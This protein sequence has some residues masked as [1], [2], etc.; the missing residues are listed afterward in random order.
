MTDGSGARNGAP[1]GP[2]GYETYSTP[3]M[4]PFV[5]E[6]LDAVDLCPGDTVL[7]LACGTGFAA[8]A[9]AALVGPTGRVRGADHDAEMIRVARERHPRLYPDIEFTVAPAD[10]L[11]YDTAAF[12]VVV[13]QQG[14]QFFPDLDAVLAEVAR[15]T[16]PEGRF[17]ATVW[18]PVDRQPYFLAQQ[19]AVHEY[20]GPDALRYFAR[21]FAVTAE[22]LTTGLRTAGYGGTAHRE[23]TFGIALPPLDAYARA[24]LSTLWGGLIRQAGGEDALDQAAALVREQLAGHLADDGTATLPFTAI[25]V[26]AT[27]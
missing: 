21:A 8:R 13:C 5:G 3:I 1:D 6:L 19:R 9:A 22:Q 16:R 10:H 27:R 17:A 7:D 15:V 11:P 12:D 20:G 26:T 25:L 2:E 24:H 18:A 14:A 4:A 23:I